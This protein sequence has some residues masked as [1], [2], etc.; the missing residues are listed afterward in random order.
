MNDIPTY[1]MT[2]MIYTI[3]FNFVEN[4]YEDAEDFDL[5][6][7]ESLRNIVK[8][9]TEDKFL[10]E[11]VKNNIHNYLTR[12]RYFQDENRF[13]RIEL[14][15]EMIGYMNSQTEDESYIFYKLELF[16]R[17]RDFRYIIGYPIETINKEINNVHDSICEDFYVLIS[18]TDITEEEIFETE[19]LPYFK[20]SKAYYESLNAILYENPSVFKDELFYNRAM[21]VINLNKDLYK[22]DKQILKMNKKLVRKINKEVK[23]VK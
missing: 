5:L 18:H 14:I 19:Y 16:K 17:R 8:Q 22:D 3:I 20:N 7:V 9:L 2:K 4:D 1:R 10:S 23:R 6:V 13:K 21:K 11:S 15:N 12:A